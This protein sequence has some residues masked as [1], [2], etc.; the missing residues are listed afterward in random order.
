MYS[1]L[2][3]VQFKEYRTNGSLHPLSVYTSSNHDS[4]EYSFDTPPIYSFVSLQHLFSATR[5]PHLTIRYWASLS[6]DLTNWRWF[7]WVLSTWHEVLNSIRNGTSNEQN[8]LRL[9][10]LR[11][12]ELS[13]LFI[14]F[15]QLLLKGRVP[16]KKRK[17]FR[18]WIKNLFLKE[19]EWKGV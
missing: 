15:I 3:F 5:L 14:F 19:G 9:F 11:S 8:N 1:F 18:N 17:N 10:L 12:V 6:L 7:L 16:L 2:H 4:S 13:V